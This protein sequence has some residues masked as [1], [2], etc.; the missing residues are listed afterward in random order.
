MKNPS[1]KPKKRPQTDDVWPWSTGS[2]P[3]I[4]RVYRRKTPSGNW[5]YMVADNS[6]HD[7][8]NRKIRRWLSYSD[9][10]FAKDQAGVLSRRIAG[11]Q[12]EASKLTNAEAIEY[13]KARDRMAKFNATV[14]T[15]TIKVEECLTHLD[16]TSLAVLYDACDYYK[17]HHTGLVAKRVA[18]VITEYRKEL[19]HHSEVYLDT[20]DCRLRKFEQF[21]QVNFNELD[22]A[23]VEQ[24]FRGLKTRGGQPFQPATFNANKAA[25]HALF[26]YAVAH[27]YCERNLMAAIKDKPENEGGAIEIYAPAEL[28]RLLGAARDLYPTLVPPLAL[29]A[30]TGARTAEVLRL[31]WENIDLGASGYVVLEARMTKTRRRRLV[32]VHDALRLWLELTRASERKGAV[33]PGGEDEFYLERKRCAAATTVKANKAK[34]IAKQDAVRWKPNA[35]RHS[36][37]SYRL[38][39]L[40]SADAVALE[41]GNSPNVIFQHYR[42][43]VKEAQAVQW[44]AVSPAAPA[45]VLPMPAAQAAKTV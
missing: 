45:N 13:V 21:A 32:P 25:L 23:S 35:M 28:E 37:I 11:N 42:E 29:G 16:T 31:D 12:V 22:L 1:K 24:W 30:F 40:K 10:A 14:E 43:L 8:Q 41:C 17:K 5:S 36:Y 18:D 26:E 38:A 27:N 33:W 7:A 39:V 3:A 9:E 44:F 20:L 15:A 6:Q 4:V 19:E 2:G 34:G